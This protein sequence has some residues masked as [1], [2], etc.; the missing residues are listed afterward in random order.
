M[1]YKCKVCDVQSSV[2]QFHKEI[3][4]RRVAEMKCFLYI[5]PAVV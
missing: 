1:S 2:S 4:Q 3:F 5:F